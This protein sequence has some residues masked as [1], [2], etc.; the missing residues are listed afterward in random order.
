[1]PS[2]S[3]YLN[4]NHLSS[5]QRA[6]KEKSRSS[7]PKKSTT[8]I[9]D[10][11]F[12][13]ISNFNHSKVKSSLKKNNFKRSENK[14][15]KKQSSWKKVSTNELI[16]KN[17]RDEV[18]K[19]LPTN[20]TNN[21]ELEKK[22]VE[23]KSEN[24]AVEEFLNESERSK[25]LKNNITDEEQPVYI[26]E[27]TAKLEKT[28]PIETK[29]KDGKIDIS[30]AM[31]ITSDDPM[32]LFKE[33]VKE[34]RNLSTKASKTGRKLY[35]RGPIPPNRFDILP[36]YRWDGVDRSNG[37]EMKWFSH[38]Q[39]KAHKETLSFQLQEDYE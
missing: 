28:N 27:N 14:I 39:A 9:D 2:V 13:S 4:K 25:F 19:T 20:N 3:D 18:N 29:E 5:K 30:L 34:A 35:D 12:S 1:M 23:D 32:L 31:Q 10:H 8:I 17:D 7:A 24:Q 16:L 21:I 33:D 26:F 37:F 36:G 11:D 38:Q 22:P 15:I 6:K